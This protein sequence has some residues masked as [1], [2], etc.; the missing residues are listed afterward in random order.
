MAK[1]ILDDYR[2]TS[3]WLATN[4][5]EGLGGDI[6]FLRCG[7]DGTFILRVLKDVLDF[8]KGWESGCLHH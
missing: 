2:T 3:G 8:H 4:S 5:R 6:G 7:K 1:V